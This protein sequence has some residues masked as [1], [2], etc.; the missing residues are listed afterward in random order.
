MSGA[1]VLQVLRE[2]ELRLLRPEIR[3]DP[4]RLGA[5]LHPEFL[6]IGASGRVY[7]R[8]EVLVEF[9]DFPQTYEVWAQDFQART[10]APGVILLLFRTA[11]VC[12]NGELSRHVAR[13]S[14]WQWTD[15]TWRL[16]FHQGTLSDPFERHEA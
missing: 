11:H 15:G 3:S 13:T 10:V 8:D 2:R 16:R 9:R 5:L 4:A 12:A 1:T 14:I 6:E 7:S